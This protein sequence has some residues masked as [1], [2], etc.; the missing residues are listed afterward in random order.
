[1][2]FEQIHSHYKYTTLETLRHMHGKH[3]IVSTMYDTKEFT[4]KF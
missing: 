1:L 3:S 2:V 4:S